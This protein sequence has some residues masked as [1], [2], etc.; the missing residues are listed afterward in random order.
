MKTQLPLFEGKEPRVATMKVSGATED[1]V[2]CLALEEEVYFVGKGTVAG[3]S[4]QDVKHQFTR[5]HKVTPSAIVIIERGDGER[6]LNEAQMM[7]DER[8]GVQNLFQPGDPR[9]PAEQ[10]P[11]GPDGP[12]VD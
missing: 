5:V 4:H 6:M 8:F 7:A 12:P 3:V 9:D 11:S 2:G 1:R 10:P